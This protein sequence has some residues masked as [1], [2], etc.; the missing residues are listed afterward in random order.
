MNTGTTY[1]KARR[2][3]PLWIVYSIAKSIKELVLF[4]ITFLIYIGSDSDS[5][6]LRFAVLSGVFYLIYKVVSILLEWIHFKYLFTEKEMCIHEGRFIKESR[7]IPLERIQGISRNTPFFHRL[8]G[9]TSLLLDIGAAGNKSSVK[10]EMI[11]CKEAERIQ[12]YFSHADYLERDVN[13][14]NEGTLKANLPEHSSRKKHYEMTSKEIFVA[15]VTSLSF[16][17]FMSLLYTLYSNLNDF[18]SIDPYIE[19]VLSFFQKSWLLTTVGIFALLVLSM[20]YGWGRTYIRYRNFEVTSD[21]QRIFIKKGLFHQS[22]FSIPKE[23]VE[24]IIVNTKFL[25]KM[26]GIVEVKIV[27]TGD[28]E[29][30]QLKTANILFP[31]I[32][33]N[34]ALLLIS[35][36]LPTFKVETEMVNLPRAA[37]FVKLVRSSYIWI[38][39]GVIFYIWPRL[40]YVPL[41]LLI[42]VH[43]SQL[44]RGLSSGYK[45]SG[46]FIQ[47][48]SGS[49]STKLFIT[50]RMK[51][52]ELKVTESVLQRKFGL[53]SL[54]I[55]TRSKSIQVSRISDI[56]KNMAIRYY[57]WYAQAEKSKE[58][59]GM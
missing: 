28:G 35:E 45:L 53:A 58:I 20:A 42:L 9:L 5:I 15:S 48:Q 17:I 25:K 37:I 55:S 10:L 24:A 29:D 49:F 57:Q 40:W 19:A 56:P 21:Q 51:I 31:F 1:D 2:I 46:P 52:E 14:P 16:L 26:L 6:F 47:L 8:F 33:K 7:Y 39:A 11:T 41:A 38:V 12:K 13:K 18:F 36:I 27:S 23:K 50:T 4:V 32:D 54:E 30:E 22:E 34:R 43:T 3:H 59:T 44:L